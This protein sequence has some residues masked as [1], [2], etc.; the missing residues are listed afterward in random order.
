M[1]PEREKRFPEA[2]AVSEHDTVDDSRRRADGPARSVTPPRGSAA[3]TTRRLRRTE[4][5]L[6]L[7]VPAGA[8]ILTVLAAEL[9]LRFPGFEGFMDFEPT[10]RTGPLVYLP[11]QV[12]RHRLGAEIDTELR[13]NSRGFRDA[14]FVS[15]PGTESAVALGDSFTEGWGV[16][17]GASW[18]KQLERRLLS[19]GFNHVYN[20][21]HNGTNPKNYAAVYGR[22]FQQ[23]PSV[24]LVILGFCLLNDII[25]PATPSQ[26]RDRPAGLG[27]RMKFVASRYS[28]LYN[29][30][31]RNIRYNPRLER[32]FSI[33]G[34]TN[35]PLITLDIQGNEWNRRRWAY[36]AEFLAS[37]GAS[38][39]AEGRRFVVVLIPPKELVVDD[40][41]ET[42]LKF[43]D[44]QQSDLDR[45][46]FRDYVMNQLHAKGTR[47]LDLTPVFRDST[48]RNPSELYLRGDG[49][50]SASGHSLAAA[51]I[52]DYLHRTGI[53]Q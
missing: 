2:A 18:P 27:K 49:H 3:P 51:T 8:V 5:L 9:V 32:V 35:P 12:A 25:E 36:T 48:V 21:G 11:N 17:V 7:I 44:V 22:F 47:I 34:L 31:H 13:I 46:G 1:N 40:Y 26:I 20:A 45:F 10:L 39:E 38:V 28:I 29:L 33:L 41:F 23:D 19:S 14:E 24:H 52:D 16:A 6:R 43:A 37:F 15:G 30:W 42:L 53:I 4:L 50:W